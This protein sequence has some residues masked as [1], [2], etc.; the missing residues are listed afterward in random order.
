MLDL[1]YFRNSS[2][3]TQIFQSENTWQT[4]IKPRGARFITIM[5][6]GAGAGGGGGFLN[7]G[8]RSGGAGGGPGNVIRASFQSSMLPDVLYILT[9]IGGA[10]G[11]GSA[12]P[13]AGSSPTRTYVAMSPDTSSAASIILTCSSTLPGGGNAGSGVNSTAGVN[14]GVPTVNNSSFSVFGTFI[15]PANYVTATGGNTG[16]AASVSAILPISMGGA[17][18]GGGSTG[19]GGGISGGGIIPIV[20]ATAANTNGANGYIIYKPVLILLSGAGGGGLTTGGNGGDGAMSCGGGGGGAGSSSAGNG[21]RGG[22][23]FV[24]ITTSF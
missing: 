16:A 18:G 24:I 22:D 15:V 1:S 13:T 11:I 5:L 10:G 14:P 9:G 8:T 23:G 6:A 20:N 21:G 17:G 7:A 3:N 19:T 2:L 12:T 4:W